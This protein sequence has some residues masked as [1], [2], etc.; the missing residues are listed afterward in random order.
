LDAA[1]RAELEML[2]AQARNK[3]GD[4]RKADIKRLLQ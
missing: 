3:A 4:V 1:L 2:R